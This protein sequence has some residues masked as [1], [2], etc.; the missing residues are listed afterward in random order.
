MRKYYLEMNNSVWQLQRSL[1]NAASR[2]EGNGDNT[3]SERDFFNEAI[4]V[5]TSSPGQQGLVCG[6]GGLSATDH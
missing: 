5:L 6:Q 3:A 1:I 4:D 2:N